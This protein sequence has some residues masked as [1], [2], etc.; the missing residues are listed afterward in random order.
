M[1]KCAASILRRHALWAPTM[2]QALQCRRCN[3]Q[4]ASAL[5]KCQS[6]LLPSPLLHSILN[7]YRAHA[8]V[9]RGSRPHLPLL[10]RLLVLLLKL[11]VQAYL[12]GACRHIIVSCEPVAAMLRADTHAAAWRNCQLAGKATRQVSPLVEPTASTLVQ[13][14]VVNGLW[15]QIW[16]LFTTRHWR[17]PGGSAARA[18]GQPA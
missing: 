18:G 8:Y 10:T 16:G 17:G 5:R 7:I 14:P 12:R 11:K 1:S 4:H 15:C 6:C 13:C 3:T 2:L 9:S